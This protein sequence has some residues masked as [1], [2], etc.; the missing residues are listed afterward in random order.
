MADK[1]YDVWIF[2][3][4]GNYYSRRHIELDPDERAFW[5]FSWTEIG[6]YDMSRVYDYVIEETGN[7]QVYVI[8]HSQGTTALKMYFN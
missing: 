8:G 4:R 3:A 2:N 5:N 1:D 6:M 7:E